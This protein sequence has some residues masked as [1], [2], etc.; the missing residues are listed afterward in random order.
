[1]EGLRGCARPGNRPGHRGSATS[2]PARASG[3]GSSTGCSA[4]SASPGEPGP[5]TSYDVIID[6]IGRVT[7]KTGLTA[8]A[9]LDENAYPTGTEDRRRADARHRGTLLNTQRMARRVELHPAR[10]SRSPARRRR[11]RHLR[12]QARQDSPEPPRPHRR[13]PRRRHR[14]GRRPG[15]PGPTPASSSDNRIRRGARQPAQRLPRAAASRRLDATDHLPGRSSSAATSRVPGPRHRRAPR[16][17]ARPP[18]AAPPS[19]APAH[20]LDRRRASPSR[21]AAQP[22]RPRPIRTLDDLREYAAR[23]G[24]TISAAPP[25]A[26]TPPASHINDPRHTANSPYFEALPMAGISTR[27]DRLGRRGLVPRGWRDGWG[28]GERRQPGAILR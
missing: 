9:V 18:S 22:P 5:L 11:S 15:H 3:T 21:P 27:S 7:T 24:I 23:H 17:P 8:I 6:T 4:R 16:R 12:G 28:D 1:M 19:S 10:A 20:Y 26:R 2:R 14:T 25:A 13:P